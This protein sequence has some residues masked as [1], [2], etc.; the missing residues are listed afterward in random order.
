MTQPQF[1]WPPPPLTSL[2]V[3]ASAARAP[4]R[5][6]FCI[7]RN[8][9]AHAVEMGAPVDK[10]TMRPVHFR[11]DASALVPSGSTIPFPP[12]TENLHYE[13]ELVVMLGKPGFRVSAEE[14]PQL[15]FGYAAGLDMTR[16]DLQLTARHQG[17]PWDV[18]K[19]FEH[20]AVCGPLVPATELELTPATAISLEVNGQMRQESTV[21]N[22]IWTIGELIADLSTFYHL[23]AGDLIYTGTP[24]GVGAVKPGDRLLGRID[25]VGELE[26]TIGQPE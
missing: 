21:S 6:I 13:M 12:G 25:G 15:V 18:G 11:K 22:M 24:E 5:R 8:Y 19:N 20:S 14:A 16:R 10:A 2:Q 17:Q 3:R 26:L 23:E 9:H 7:A 4:V 1:L